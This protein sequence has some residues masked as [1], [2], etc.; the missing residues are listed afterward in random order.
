M[1]DIQECA[2]LNV[3]KSELLCC[4]C[5]YEDQALIAILYR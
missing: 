5:E 1:A 4:D 2:Q 3:L